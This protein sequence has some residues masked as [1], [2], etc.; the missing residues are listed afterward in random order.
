MPA[1]V[2]N[3]E[4]ESDEIE[5]PM[6]TDSQQVHSDPVVTGTDHQCDAGYPAVPNPVLSISDSDE[7]PTE[8][9]HSEGGPD[10]AEV[11]PAQDPPYVTLNGRTSKPPQRLICDP[12]WSQKA[13]V[14]LSLANSQNQE[15]LQN[16]SRTGSSAETLFAE[17][18][19]C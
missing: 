18:F 17:S 19:D 10:E 15:L 1:G 16:F 13:S 9:T 12:V 8:V 14:L 11:E 5:N 7:R 3:P 6:Q 4:A 2:E